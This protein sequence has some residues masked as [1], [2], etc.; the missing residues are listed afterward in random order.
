[1]P[2]QFLLAV[3]NSFWSP[4]R[5]RAA[6][7]QASSSEAV[8]LP[9]IAPLSNTSTT[10]DVQNPTNGPQLGSQ[11]EGSPCLEKPNSTLLSFRQRFVGWR[12]SVLSFAICASIVFLV[13]LTV[14]IVGYLFYNTTQGTLKKGDCQ[15][16]K[17]LNRG[18]HILINIFSTILLSGSNY[19]MQC[20][21]APT[22]EE[23]NQA[24]AK[25]KWLDIG[26]PSVRNLTHIS[27]KRLL[28][29]MLLGLSSLPLHL[30]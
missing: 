16:I 21:S 13:N 23:V 8:E 29:W 5:I 24:H 4:K 18:L 20:L 11:D 14:T 2:P 15:D 1:M 3:T 6:Y 27:R 25:N 12:C 9:M 10:T 28:L 22:R 17:N 19:C 30:L 26:I 7:H